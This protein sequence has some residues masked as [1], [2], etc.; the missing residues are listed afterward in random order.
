LS[1]PEGTEAPD[2][3]LKGIKIPRLDTLIFNAAYGGWSGLNIPLAIWEILTKGIVQSVT[4]PTFKVAFPTR[5]LNERPE[6]K[7]VSLTRRLQYLWT[8]C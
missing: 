1:N 8:S 6:Y 5:L 3:K 7:Y 2:G 4:W